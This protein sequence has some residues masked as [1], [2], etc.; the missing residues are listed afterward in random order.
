MAPW[1]VY[2][3]RKTEKHN[4]NSTRLP[5]RPMQIP[6][7]M[8]TVKIDPSKLGPGFV[9]EE[10]VEF[11]EAVVAYF[12]VLGF[13]QKKD[14]KDVEMTL[15]DFVGALALPAIVFKN[16]RFSVFS[17]C[18]FVA[19]PR[20]SSGDLL[21]AVRYAFTQWSADSVPVRGGI[22]IGSYREMSVVAL[23]LRPNL[24]GSIFAGSAVTEAVRHESS[25]V[26]AL[27]FASDECAEFYKS[28]HKEPIFYQPGARV[29]EW[30]DDESVLYWFVGVSL[31]RLLKVLSIENGIK[32]SA[33]PHLLS[34]VMYCL[35]A[36]GSPR[37]R[38][39]VLSLLSLPKLNPQSREVAISLLGIR[40][41][42]DF[43]L[44]QELID[45]WLSNNTR[46]KTLERFADFDSSIPGSL[47]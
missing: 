39:V 18:A 47:Y 14:L 20:A 8:R 10:T 26:G 9:P 30:S 17:D 15:L 24:L 27:L 16:I 6:A 28:H 7:D 29:I 22:A 45:E 11:K 19:A 1:D 46:A 35:A 3:H 25:G 40:D 13:S 12:D 43:Q 41:P 32:H 33:T 36:T 37:L 5:I 4:E 23:K 38:L 44:F 21:A 34:N 31:L 42:D 2:M